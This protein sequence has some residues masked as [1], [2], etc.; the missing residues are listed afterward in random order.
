MCHAIEN[1]EEDG[2]HR[3]TVPPKKDAVLSPKFYQSPTQR[4]KHV[5]F[6]KKHGRHLWENKVKHYRRLLV[7]NTIGRYKKIIGSKLKSRDF[8]AQE[9]EVC[10]GC[11]IINTMFRLGTPLHPAVQ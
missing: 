2:F 1:R 3:I 5:G 6:I 10:L 8:E 7:E 9:N 4:D 11:K